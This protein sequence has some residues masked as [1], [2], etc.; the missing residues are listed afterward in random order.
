MAFGEFALL[1]ERGAQKKNRTVS[2]TERLLKYA[3]IHTVNQ[4]EHNDC[5]IFWNRR[6][7]KR[8]ARPYQNSLILAKHVQFVNAV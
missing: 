6:D 5:P 8:T 3:Y 2:Y 4:S 7:V 1:T